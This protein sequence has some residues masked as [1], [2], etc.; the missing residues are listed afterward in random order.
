MLDNLITLKEKPL[1]LLMKYSY[2]SPEYSI[3]CIFLNDTKYISS[4]RK[5]VNYFSFLI[6]LFLF[7]V[8]WLFVVVFFAYSTI[9]TSFRCQFNFA[10]FLIYFYLYLLISQKFESF[11]IS[12]SPNLFNSLFLKKIRNDFQFFSS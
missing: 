10:V 11:P 7:L 2:T 12:F 9:L 4:I 8:V 6:L 5:T 3:L 1:H